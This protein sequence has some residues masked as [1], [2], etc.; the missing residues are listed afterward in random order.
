MIVGLGFGDHARQQWWDK[1]NYTQLD[2]AP[3][4]EAAFKQAGIQLEDI[5]CAQ[6]YD[7]FT[8]EVVFQIEDYGW[9][10][11]GQGGPFAAEGAMAPG[12]IIPVNT[13]GGMLSGYYL[14][15]YTGLAEAV[16][17]L[18]G[19]GGARQVK[20]AEIALVTGH[21]GEM[22]IPGMCSTHACAILGR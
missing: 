1:T 22:V 18:R 15:D 5:D 6:F 7:C 16:V 9:C 14:F 19:E 13:G 20:D 11:K 10:K 2:V 3:A 21:G 17:Q 4:K 8:A 12:G